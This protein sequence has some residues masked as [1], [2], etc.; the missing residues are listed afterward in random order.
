MP[1]DYPFLK[2]Y[3]VPSNMSTPTPIM[4]PGCSCEPYLGPVELLLCLVSPLY[5]PHP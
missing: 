4:S 1:Q 2:N 5:I 3:K